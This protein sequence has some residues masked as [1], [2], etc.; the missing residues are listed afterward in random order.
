MTAPEILEKLRQHVEAPNQAE[1]SAA[2]QEHLG[3][4]EARGENARLAWMMGLGGDVESIQLTETRFEL[5]HQGL[6]QGGDS[7]WAAI[8]GKQPAESMNLGWVSVLDPTVLPKLHQAFITMVQQGASFWEAISIVSAG[9]AKAAFLELSKSANHSGFDG[10]IT[11]G[12]ASFEPYLQTGESPADSGEILWRRMQK[13]GKASVIVGAAAACVAAIAFSWHAS[14]ITEAPSPP[15]MAEQKVDSA[16]EA[17]QAEHVLRQYH[18]SDTL[19]E[20]AQWVLGGS[21]LLPQMQ[22]F[23]EGDRQTASAVASIHRWDVISIDG[24]RHY[25]AQ[26]VDKRGERFLTLVNLMNEEPKVDWEASVGYGEMSLDTFT[27]TQATKPVLLR[28]FARPDDYYNHTFSDSAKF[29]CFALSNGDKSDSTYAYV[30]RR[31]KAYEQLMERFPN[32]RSAGR[33]PVRTLAA[34]NFE[35]DYLTPQKVTLRVAFTPPTDGPA[36]VEIKEVLGQQWVV[37]M[38]EEN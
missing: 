6:W 23:Y 20:R 22:S 12:A 13:T 11:V 35:I 7:S 4:G 19:E 1:A 10:R 34:A 15:V 32:H 18:D 36:Q 14:T 2:P 5:D 3:F 30:E 16:R 33:K 17:R 8:T 26:G 29:A 38:N 21:S 9:E 37:A 28:L 27:K 25:V 31:S 24:H